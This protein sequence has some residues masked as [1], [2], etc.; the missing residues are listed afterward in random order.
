MPGI[1]SGGEVDATQPGRISHSSDYTI[2]SSLSVHIL[3]ILLWEKNSENAMSQQ[4]TGSEHRLMAA[5]SG[6]M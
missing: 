3:F 1:P 5:I 6:N 2:G 4:S